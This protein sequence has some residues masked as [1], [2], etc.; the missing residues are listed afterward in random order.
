VLVHVLTAAGVNADGHRKV[1]RIDV[2]SAED[3]AGGWLAFFRDLS[4]RGLSGVSLV[5][6]DAHTGLVGI[7]PNGDALIRLVGPVLAE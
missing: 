2:T 1:L 6:S 7:F 5:I 4:V 3:G